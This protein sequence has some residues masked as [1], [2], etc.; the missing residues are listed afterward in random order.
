VV[1]KRFEGLAKGTAYEDRVEHEAAVFL[2]CDSCGISGVFK[3]VKSTIAKNLGCK[4]RA[5]YLLT[6]NT[7]LIPNY[8]QYTE[9]EQDSILAGWS[10]LYD[11]S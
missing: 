5:H 2:A 11:G 6:L 8:S 3:K 7:S 4:G 9:K 1:I 10:E